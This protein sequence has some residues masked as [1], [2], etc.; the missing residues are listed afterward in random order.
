MCGSHMYGARSSSRSGS[1]NRYC[2]VSAGTS[3]G[4]ESRNGTYAASASKTISSAAPRRDA[5]ALASSA[6][7]RFTRT[8]SGGRRVPLGA[9]EADHAVPGQ[10]LSH[11]RDLR[12]EARPWP[13]P[14]LDALDLDPR[15]A[16]HIAQRWADVH[17]E[18]MLPEAVLA[19][20]AVALLVETRAEPRTEELVRGHVV[21]APRRVP[22][23]P[24]QVAPAARSEHPLHVAD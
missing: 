9:A 2:F 3:P 23:G 14:R 13:V 22:V 1:R 16:A 21:T 15:P 19:R 17:R 10:H 8:G 11:A 20:R 12:D 5:R 4:D 6:P 24:R 7:S 18:Q